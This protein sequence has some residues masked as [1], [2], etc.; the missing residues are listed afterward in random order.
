MK[1]GANCLAKYKRIA[2]TNDHAYVRY[3][4][5][6]RKGW[7]GNSVRSKVEILKQVGSKYL[8]CYPDT[9]GC[10]ERMVP[11]Y[12]VSGIVQQPR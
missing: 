12:M 9:P 2:I 3:G 1:S 11:I 5:I 7:D 10:P 4:Y 6:E 8:V